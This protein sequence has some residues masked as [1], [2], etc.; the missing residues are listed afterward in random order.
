MKVSRTIITTN[1]KYRTVNKY[2]ILTVYRNGKEW[3]RNLKGDKYILSL[4]QRIEDLEDQVIALTP[5]IDILY[6][7]M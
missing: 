6:K 1:G 3:N 2:G 4:I 7:G 5:P